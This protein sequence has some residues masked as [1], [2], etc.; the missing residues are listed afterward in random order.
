MPIDQTSGVGVVTEVNVAGSL[1]KVPGGKTFTGVAVLL[2]AAGS[3]QVVIED[4]SD[5]IYASVGGAQVPVTPVIVSMVPVIGGGS[6]S[7]LTVVATGTTSLVSAV[8]AGY[9][10]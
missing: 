8:V 7:Q 5:N 2:L 10:K 4:A 9:Y 1:Y 6:G 3:G